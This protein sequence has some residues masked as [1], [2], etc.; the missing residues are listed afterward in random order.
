MP[1]N[2]NLFPEITN[3]LTIRT[4]SIKLMKEKK[5]KQNYYLF[6][7]LILLYLKSIIALILNKFFVSRNNK[8]VKDNDHY[9]SKPK[10]IFNSYKSPT[11]SS[12]CHQNSSHCHQ[13]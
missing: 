5:G 1:I 2:I 13:N 4:L 3:V 7:Y 11:P 9:V 8:H 12:H 6:F 10:L